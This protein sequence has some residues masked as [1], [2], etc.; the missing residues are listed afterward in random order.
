[1]YSFNCLKWFIKIEYNFDK[2]LHFYTS[3]F[4]MKQINHLNNYQKF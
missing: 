3:F 2:M 1:M 4:Q